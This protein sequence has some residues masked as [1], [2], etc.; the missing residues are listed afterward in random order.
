MSLRIVVIDD[1]QDDLEMMGEVLTGINDG[2][3]YFPFSKAEEAMSTLSSGLFKANFI[4]IDL[5]MPR[6]GGEDCIK[7]LRSLPYFNTT[8][9]IIY[10]TLVDPNKIENL[11]QLGATHCFQKPCR[12]DSLEEILQ[13][14]ISNQS[15][16]LNFIE[17]TPDAQVA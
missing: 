3:E 12:L 14:I 13:N 16:N 17:P 11:R 5:H 10:T 2:V 9:I 1:D 8:P 6:L 15:M 7:Q 4:F